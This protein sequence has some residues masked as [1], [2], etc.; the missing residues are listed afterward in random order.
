MAVPP[1]VAVSLECVSSGHNQ[2][3]LWSGRS[4]RADAIA[5]PVLGWVPAAI[6]HLLLHARVLFDAVLSG[7]G[8]VDRKRANRFSRG[9]LGSQRACGS[10]GGRDAGAGRHR[11]HP[12]AGV[13]P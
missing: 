11:L 6:L 12:A 1:T 9:I 3:E 8:V 13:E 2:T 5:V 10:G 7:A 4:G